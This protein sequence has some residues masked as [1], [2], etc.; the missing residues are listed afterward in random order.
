LFIQDWKDFASFLSKAFTFF[1]NQSIS[2]TE[3][4]FPFFTNPF[5]N[6]DFIDIASKRLKLADILLY[7]WNSVRNRVPTHIAINLLLGNRGLVREGPFEK[8]RSIDVKKKGGFRPG[9]H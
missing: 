5:G 8:N 7:S 2:P 9:D 4:P 1:D 6:H 3:A